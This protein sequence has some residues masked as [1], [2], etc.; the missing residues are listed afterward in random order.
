MLR[1][2]PVVTIG[3]WK[4]FSLNDVFISLIEFAL[5]NYKLIAVNLLLNDVWAAS[6]SYVARGVTEIDATTDEDFHVCLWLPKVIK[7]WLHITLGFLKVF[8]Y[9]NWI[10]PIWRLHKNFA[11]IHLYKMRQSLKHLDNLVMIMGK[12]SIITI[13]RVLSYETNVDDN[14]EMLIKHDLNKLS[15]R[16][17]FSI[18]YCATQ[19]FIS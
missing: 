15:S 11:T 17:I 3:W 7:N 4:Y 19:L 2:F 6:D 1:D 5:R 14:N 16:S 9:S 18:V 12:E 13:E 10:P 8:C